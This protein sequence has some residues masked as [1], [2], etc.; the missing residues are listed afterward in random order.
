[1]TWFINLGVYE[2]YKEQLIK[3]V[4]KSFTSCPIPLNGLLGLGSCATFHGDIKNVARSLICNYNFIPSTH[5]SGGAYMECIKT[6]VKNLIDRR[7]LFLRDG[8]DSNVRYMSMHRFDA[9]TST[10]LTK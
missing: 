9:Y 6:N 8:K 4:G 10:A 2:K 3:L 7:A 5:M 1:M